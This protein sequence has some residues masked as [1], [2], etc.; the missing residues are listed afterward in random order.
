MV[1]EFD[2]TDFGRLAKPTE[3]FPEFVRR[4]VGGTILD[5]AGSIRVHGCGGADGVDMTELVTTKIGWSEQHGWKCGQG[6]LD[7][8]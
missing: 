8:Y 3:V 5:L 1:L 4:E 2:V 6:N 7:E